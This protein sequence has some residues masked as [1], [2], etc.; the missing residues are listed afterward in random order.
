MIKYFILNLNGF[1]NYRIL[2]I[3]RLIVFLAFMFAFRETVARSVLVFIFI[4]WITV[5]KKEEIL[6][7]FKKPVVAWLTLF[8]AMLASTT[9]YLDSE[10]IFAWKFVIRFS[11]YLLIPMIMIATSIRKDYIVKVI[12]AFIAGM[13][14]NEIISYGIVFDL[15]LH[16]EDGYPVYFMAHVFYSVLLSFVMMLLIYKLMYEKSIL[17]KIVASI[18]LVTMFGNLVMSGGRTGQITFIITFILTFL[19]YQRITL[20]TLVTIFFTPI[21]AIFITYNLYTPFQNRADMFV[22]DTQKAFYANDFESSFGTRLFAY[23]LTEK[24]FEVKDTQTILFGV[25]ID[26]VQ[27]KKTEFIKQYFPNTKNMQPNFMQFHSSYVDA[28]WWTGL[29]GFSFVMMFLVSI[30]RINVVDNQMRYIKLA[31]FFTLIFSYL[32]DSSLDNQYIMILTAIFVGL[33]LAQ[34]KVEKIKSDVS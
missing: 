12:T 33:L 13:L 28:I 25:G 4:L 2:W 1:E 34:E 17:L 27:K 5:I 11:L 9:V 29:V 3:N 20:K 31:L 23:V 6:S 21:L 18:F 7:A 30:F 8:I 15:W 26:D 32:P 24:M 16:L 19:T 10:H 14:V 22:E